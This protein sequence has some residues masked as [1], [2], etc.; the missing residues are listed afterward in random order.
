MNTLIKSL[1]KVVAL[2]VLSILCSP[3]YAIHC[4]NVTTKVQ[5][6]PDRASIVYVTLSQGAVSCKVKF[7]TPND[8]TWT[9]KTK[10]DALVAAITSPVQNDP[11]SECMNRKFAV[12]DN[13]C[14]ATAPSFPSFT[15]T[16]TNDTGAAVS[17]GISNTGFDQNQDN[18]SAPLPNY[19]RE[20][21]TPSWIKDTSCGV[22]AGSAPQALLALKGTATGVSFIAGQPA[23]I[24]VVVEKANNGGV[25]TAKVNT[26]AGQ[27]AAQIAPLLN[28]QLGLAATCS[29]VT[30]PFA[31][32]LCEQPSTGTGAA[33]GFGISTSDIGIGVGNASGP[34][35]S[36]MNAFN[37]PAAVSNTVPLPLPALVVL[38]SLLGGAGI[39][40]S[41]RKR[42]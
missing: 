9:L 14:A 21:I 33:D 42:K 38:A 5:L 20:I 2:P 19:E 7:P 13:F 3:V 6:S 39:V 40:V 32:I 30:S 24:E 16:G 36:I 25:T 35:K 41:R 23:A 37:G 22:V 1:V 12:T 26:T 27:T 17:L 34:A 18:T 28:A 11:D 4:N 10:C 29:V 15:V 8:S 31:A